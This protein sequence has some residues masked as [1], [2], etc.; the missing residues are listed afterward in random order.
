VAPNKFG[1]FIL[2]PVLFAVASVIITSQ[3]FLFAT[4][5]VLSL[6]KLGLIKIATPIRGPVWATEQRMREKQSN[7]SPIKSF[8]FATRK[9]NNIFEKDSKE[10]VRDID[11]HVHKTKRN[12]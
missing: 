11:L 9:N 7:W 6:F 4:N 10:S 1:L 3:L 8:I 5:Y 2:L 12:S